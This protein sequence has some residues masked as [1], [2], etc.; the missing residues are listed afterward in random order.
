MTFVASGTTGFLTFLQTWPWP[1]VSG[2]CGAAAFSVVTYT[3]IVRPW[4]RRRRLTRPFRAYFVIPPRQKSELDNVVQD[5]RV[6]LVKEIVVRSHSEVAIEIVLFPKLRFVQQEI[7]FGCEQGGV[8]E[9]P[10][11]FEYFSSFVRQGIRGTG[12]PD[13]GHYIDDD[14]L[15]HVRESHLYVNDPRRIGFKVKTKKS[16]IYPAQVFVVAD[17]A[18]GKTTGLTIKVEDRPSTKCVAP[19]T[20]NALLRRKRRPRTHTAD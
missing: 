1:M 8:A 2:L 4:V 10:C 7:Y 11:P 18:R 9:K 15:Y 17:E 20:A 13:K 16:G 19:N 14:G 12:K 3:Q 6:H 5:D